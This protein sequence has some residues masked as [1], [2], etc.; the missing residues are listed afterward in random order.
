MKLALPL[1]VFLAAI[2]CGAGTAAADDAASAADAATRVKEI[3]RTRCFDCHGGVET[4]AGVDVLDREGLVRKDKVAPDAPDASLLYQRI[5]AKDDSVMPPDGEPRLSPEEIAAVRAWI[6]AGAPDFPA[7]AAAPAEPEKDAGL[8]GVV[9]V[10]Y[11]L[12]QILAHVRSLS[13]R[14]R[15]FVRYFSTNHLLTGGATREELDLHR[16]ALA[17][18]INHLS[19]QP[20]IVRPEAI[21]GEI[22][23]VFA[24]DIRRLGWHDR[25]F[26]RVENGRT[27][28]TA[29]VNLYDLALLEYP[30]AILYEDSE[31]LDRLVQEYLA[32]SGMVRPIPYLRA[33]W[34]ASIATQ[35]PLYEDF[36]RLP[37]ELAEFEELLGVDSEANV[38]DFIARRAGMTVSGVSRNNRV[39]E[40][41]PHRHGAYWKSFDFASSRGRQNMFHNPLEFDEDGG[42]FIFN[43]PNG[44]QGY[45]VSDAAG[46]RLVEAPTS[47]VTDKFAED[48]TV[49][50][51]LSCMRCHERGV[52]T[53]TDTIRP[54]VESLPGSP[55]FKK[56]D[57]LDLYPTQE[58]M[59]ELLKEDE[60]RFMK[61]ME[62][63]LGRP[64][65]REP[66]I[67]VS[68]RFL[69]A[70]LHLSPAAA[71]LGLPDAAHLAALSRAPQFVSLG[72]A[73]LASGG[74]VR[75]DMWEDYYDDIV[76][77]L[78]LGAPVIPLD[79]LTISEYTLQ[80]A[81][82]EI[83]LSTGSKTNVFSAGGELVISVVNRSAKDAHI[84]LIGTSAKGRKVILTPPG[85]IVR[86]GETFRFPEKGA[87]E[88]QPTV[89]K[90]QITLFACDRPFPI[91]QLLRGEGVADRVMHRF[92]DPQS[93]RD[94]EP[95]LDPS[96][97]IKTTIAIE[98]R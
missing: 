89:G 58:E 78:G 73:P 18:A 91:G 28:G 21:D 96:R 93:L 65:T 24:V 39:V 1:F 55:G 92:Y 13:A 49:R 82:L 54:A 45:F 64:Q 90:E 5:T 42:E 2:V 7:D 63:V 31:T 23:T 57:V 16:D 35:P 60:E 4:N 97:M 41:H 51:G 52:K 33:D 77:Q 70:P 88:I 15:P 36:L 76:R 32:P 44:L 34:F 38:A 17:K 81:P 56:R 61:A 46:R 6:V 62:Q 87:I 98:T 19:M 25:P 74:L 26:Q 43:L 83:E 12:K 11:V 29:D 84:E 85:T 14:D 72:L 80:P 50:N 68:Q 59:D 75:R 27:T 20:Q 71:E 94:N 8:E 10:D 79:G 48:K 3:F 30:Y 37:F 86:A 66:L 67:P 69:D 9:G 40:R 47:I 53:F 95:A 22:A